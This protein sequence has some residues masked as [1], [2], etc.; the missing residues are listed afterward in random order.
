MNSPKRTRRS[1]EPPYT[2]DASA[3]ARKSPASMSERI[4]FSQRRSNTSELR[5]R[6]FGDVFFELRG[7]DLAA[8]NGGSLGEMAFELAEGQW[9]RG[10]D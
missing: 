3:L 9:H 10:G 6:N 5:F 4:T 2:A 7:V 1:G 8:Q